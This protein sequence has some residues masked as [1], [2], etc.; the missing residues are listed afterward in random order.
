MLSGLFTLSVLC[1]R[2][3]ARMASPRAMS[4]YRTL[5]F[6]IFVFDAFRALYMHTATSDR[7]PAG[8]L[9]MVVP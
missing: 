9:S 1:P 2:M 7:P 3:T 5:T 6:A 4:K 8:L